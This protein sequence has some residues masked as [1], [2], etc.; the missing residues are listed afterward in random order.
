MNTI[1][2]FWQGFNQRAEKLERQWPFDPR[3]YPVYAIVFGLLA[4]NIGAILATDFTLR[5]DN[6]LGLFCVAAFFTGLGLLARTYGMS[7]VATAFEIMFLPTVSGALAIVA[8]ALLC[9]VSAPP[10]D[11]MLARADQSLGLDW[12]ALLQFYKDHDWLIPASEYAYRLMM[13]QMYLVPIFLLIAGKHQQAWLFVSAW[14]ITALIT[15]LVFPLFPAVGPF[16]HYGIAPAASPYPDFAWDWMFGERIAGVRSGQITEIA[17]AVGGLITFPSFHTA[18]G[19]L[20][21]WI[22]W[23]YRMVRPVTLILNVMMIMSTPIR[24]AHYFVDIPGGIAVAGAAIWLSRAYVAKGL[25][26][27]PSDRSL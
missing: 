22:T 13:Q 10:V 14:S 6:R 24:G 5:F 21:I 17:D 4:L 3:S 25:H 20:F 12:L 26:R 7:R 15:A 2:G 19:V 27:A 1:V 23:P 16:V 11:A 18:A 9:R 8:S